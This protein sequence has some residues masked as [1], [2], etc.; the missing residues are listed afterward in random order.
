MGVDADSTVTIGNWVGRLT[1]P[2]AQAESF[3]AAEII[4]RATMLREMRTT[5]PPAQQRAVLDQL[6]R[7]YAE[8]FEALAARF[9][10]GKERLA[11]SQLQRL[12]LLERAEDLPYLA[13]EELLRH[14]AQTV[15]AA[16][17]ESE[18]IADLNP[19]TALEK[20]P[21]TLTEAQTALRLIKFLLLMSLASKPKLPTALTPVLLFLLLEVLPV[22][23]DRTAAKSRRQKPERAL[24][25]PGHD[26]RSKPCAARAPGCAVPL[27]VLN[28]EGHD[29]LCAFGGTL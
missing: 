25:P 16:S 19:G 28:S 21:E 4:D 13:Y 3:S 23:K 5:L 10:A 9:Q 15:F 26:L 27:A 24:R 8:G 14:T 1:S 29:G 17:T 6:P 22:A 11:S 2:A 7:G 12:R 20:R 18:L